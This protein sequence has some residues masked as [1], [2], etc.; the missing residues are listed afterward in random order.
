MSLVYETRVKSLAELLRSVKDMEVDTGV[1]ALGVYDGRRSLIFITKHSGSY[2][3]WIR[4]RNEKGTGRG[5][6]LSF[7]DFEGLRGFLEKALDRPLR[8]HMY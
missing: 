5:A 3:L 8:A 4:D 6:F 1:R 7:R 2:A